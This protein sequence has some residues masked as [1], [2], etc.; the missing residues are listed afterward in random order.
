MSMYYEHMQESFA[1]TFERMTK[2]WSEKKIHDNQI[3]GVINDHRRIWPS[4]MVVPPVQK[5]CLCIL[6]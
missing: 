6:W 1:K 3:V 4:I 2:Q 5:Q